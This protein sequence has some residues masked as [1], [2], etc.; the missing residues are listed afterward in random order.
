MR[1]S[2]RSGLRD[3]RRPNGERLVVWVIAALVVAASAFGLYFGF[4]LHGSEAS[5]EAVKTND[6]ISLTHEDGVYAL[7]PAD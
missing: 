3:A 2:I 7:E 5:I 6:A 1:G 4:G